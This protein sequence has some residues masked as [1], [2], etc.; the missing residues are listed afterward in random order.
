MKVLVTGGAGYIGSHASRELLEAGHEVSILDDLSTGHREALPAAARFVLGDIG[1]ASAL[2]QGLDGAGAVMHFAA[3][4]YVGDS[5]RD[6]A[7]YY[8]TNLGKGLALLW[9][10]LDAGVERFVFSST[11]AT[12]GEPVRLPM[13]ESHPQQPI[14]PYGATKLAFERA[15]QDH[16][17]ASPL[18]VIALRYFNAAGAHPD[19]SLGEHHDPEPHL[20]PL[21]IDA[22]LGRRPGLTIFGDDYDTPDGT[23][24]RDYVHVVDLARA[25][26][27]ALAALGSGPRFRAFN[28]GTERGSSVREVVEAVARVSGRGVPVS[29]GPRRAGDPPRLVASS[30][31]AQAELGFR[32]RYSLEDSVESAFRWRL[33]HP[34]GYRRAA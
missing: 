24:V 18:R 1:D 27:Q 10:A 30:A 14:N 25:H 9:A 5:M 2:R 13:D 20:I 6:P 12:Y 31:R 34:Q 11:C 28:L 32:P 33:A 17:L 15:L 4:A 21:A 23:C 19:G 26:V 8:R 29:I 16:A 22:A 3:L 7:S